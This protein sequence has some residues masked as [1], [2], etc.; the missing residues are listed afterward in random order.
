[1]ILTSFDEE[2]ATFLKCRR[3]LVLVG[4]GNRM[5]RD[6]GIGTRIITSLKG[7]VPS[8]VELLDGGTVPE[9]YISIIKKAGPSHAIF[10]DAVDMH[11]KPGFFGFI[12][13]ETLVSGSISTH[14]QS[15]KMLF[16]V[17][18]DGVDDINIRLVGVQPKN[19]EFGIGLTAPLRRSLKLLQ[20][21]LVNAL[22]GQENEDN[23]MEG[24][25]GLH[26]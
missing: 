18:R 19:I 3:K 13:E 23:R 24:R 6:D 11:A 7:K 1:V 12:D 5:R 4:I 22:E 17:L 14:K 9:N 25:R 10:I 26:N 20:A 21:T 2:L 16:L 8:D 15:L